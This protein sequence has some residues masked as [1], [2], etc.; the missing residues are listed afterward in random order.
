[1]LGLAWYGGCEMAQYHDARDVHRFSRRGI[2]T[3]SSVKGLFWVF[4]AIAGLGLLVLIGSLGGGSTPVD[5][6]GGAGAEPVITPADPET[7]P[8]GAGTLVE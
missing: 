4:V 6:P 3:G 2:D 5:H 1:M 8:T 7:A